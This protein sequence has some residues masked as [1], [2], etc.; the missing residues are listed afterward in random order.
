MANADCE[1]DKKA[2]TAWIVTTYM[3][4]LVQIAMIAIFMQ[5]KTKKH[6][7]ETNELQTEEDEN[8]DENKRTY[9]VERFDETFTP[10]NEE[11]ID[12]RTESGSML[13]QEQKS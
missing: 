1:T 13:E 7:E 9:S 6:V 8:E 12:T 10:A 5:L 3:N 2:L 11:L 4:L